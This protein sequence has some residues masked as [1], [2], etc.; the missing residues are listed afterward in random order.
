MVQRDV[1]HRGGLDGLGSSRVVASGVEDEVASFDG[2]ADDPS[3]VAV[4]DQA[5]SDPG[6]QVT[7]FLLLQ[8]FRQLLLTFHP[9]LDLLD[10]NGEPLVLVVA[11]VAGL[12]CLGRLRF[13]DQPPEWHLLIA[14]LVTQ[15]MRVGGGR[16]GEAI[17]RL[18]VAVAAQGGEQGGM[19]AVQIRIV[20]RAPRQAKHAPLAF[21]GH[22]L[23]LG[24][25]R[26]DEK[27]RVG[28][29]RGSWKMRLALAGVLW[30]AA[31]VQRLSH[32]VSVGHVNVVLLVHLEGFHIVREVC[33]APRDGFHSVVL[34]VLGPGWHQG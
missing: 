9:F 10:C 17:R 18:H 7:Q 16:D 21:V 14:K 24:D 22:S 5:F 25:A 2:A 11:G 12:R 19:T 23:L 32:A 31:V 33:G 1:R 6:T 30:V 26:A 29:P 3:P 20:A 27:G 8:V 28:Q 13:L 15:L 34:L 4:G